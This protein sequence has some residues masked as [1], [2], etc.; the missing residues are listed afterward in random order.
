MNK[1]SN[2]LCLTRCGFYDCLEEG[3][4]IGPNMSTWCRAHE[5]ATVIFSNIAPVGTKTE[6]TTPVQFSFAAMF[7]LETMLVKLYGRLIQI[8]NSATVVYFKTHG[9]Y[10]C[11]G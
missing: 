7:V 5:L 9:P 2:L 8:L 3:G 6:K 11:Q 1:L 4:L 10:E